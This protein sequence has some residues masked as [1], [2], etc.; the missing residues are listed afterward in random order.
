MIKRNYNMISSAR[1]LLIIDELVQKKK[2]D[3]KYKGYSLY[4]YLR[5]LIHAKNLRGNVHLNSI[6][7]S[8]ILKVCP[9]EIS[10]SQNK[11]RHSSKMFPTSK[12]LCVLGTSEQLEKFQNSPHQILSLFNNGTCRI[13][14]NSND[15]SYKRHIKL[16]DIV[17]AAGQFL[18]ILLQVIRFV[19]V[20]KT[21]IFA[22][23]RYLIRF[24]LHYKQ[25]ARVFSKKEFDHILFLISHYGNEATLIYLRESNVTIL[26]MQHG[27]LFPDHFGYN[28]KYSEPSDNSLPIPN[29]FLFHDKGT[30][31]RM[32]NVGK[33]RHMNLTTFKNLPISRTN[34]QRVELPYDL[35]IFSQPGLISSREQMMEFLSDVFSKLKLRSPQRVAVFAHPRE[36]RTCQGIDYINDRINYVQALKSHCVS[37]TTSMS[38]VYDSVSLG[39]EIYYA[40]F[41][42]D[43]IKSGLLETIGVQY[44]TL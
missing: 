18:F 17:F 14:L 37:F 13:S 19:Y 40:D 25:V 23:S 30:E 38:V 24:F 16:E 5:N 36:A 39:E 28:L 32:K 20:T 26:E 29:W 1:D 27:V 2:A 44:E 21:S 43:I 7:I 11:E 41:R 12:N 8:K 15:V 34:Q 9:K 22:I 3:I 35:I 4:P 31:D 10:R 6:E 33:F 42:N